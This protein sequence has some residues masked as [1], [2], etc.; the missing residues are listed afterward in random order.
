M[1][2]LIARHGH[3][4][5][6]G[7]QGVSK[8]AERPLSVTGKKQITT[9]A[10]GLKQLGVKPELIFCSPFLRTRETANIYAEILN[11]ELK[12]IVSENLQSGA[13]YDNYLEVFE[14]H[15]LWENF[16]SKCVMF[17]GHAPDV[18][19]VC[20]VLASLK[21][22]CLDTGNVVQIHLDT[23]GNAG[24]LTGFYSPNSFNNG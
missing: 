13:R 22:L 21:G 16:A 17:V 3:A 2:C 8:D 9:M 24:I 15:K 10:K 5:N 19:K 14:E 6:V 7:E 18:G 1:I 4:I 20:D 23:P 12:I 11:K